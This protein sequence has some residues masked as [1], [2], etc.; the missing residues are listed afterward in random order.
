MVDSKKIESKWQKAW[1]EAKIFEL[2]PSD[3]PGVL[4]TAAFPYVNTPQHIGHLRTYGIA[5]AYARYLRMRGKNALF[6]MGFH[7]TGTPIIGIAKRIANKDR[8]LIE[9]LRTFHIPESDMAKMTEPSFIADYFTNE[10]EVGMKRSGLSVDWRRKFVSTEPLYSKMVE[11]QFERLKELG[12]LVQGRHPVGWCPNEN[13]AV[14]QHDTK[15]DVQPE[16]EQLTMVLFKDTASDSYFGCSTYRPET[17]YGVTNIFVN[18]S[19]DYVVAKIGDRRLYLAKQSAELMKYQFELT[20][21]GSITA[22]ELLSK[23]AKSPIDGSEIPVLPGYFVKPDVGTGVVMSVPSHAPFDYVALKRLENSGY[24]LPKMEFRKLI[25]IEKA[26]GKGVGLSVDES[27]R[28]G[29]VAHPEVPALAYLE[30]FGTNAESTDDAIEFATK[31]AYREESRWGVMLVGKYK[32]KGEPEARDLIKA[33]LISSGDAIALYVLANPAPVICRCGTRAVVRI[34]DNQ[35]FINY[36]DKG[37]K[38]KAKAHL[39]SMK[40]YPE[41]LRKTYENAMDWIEMRAAERA[42]GLGTRFPFNRDHIIEPLSDSTIYMSLYSFIHILR[43]NGVQPDSLKREFFDYVYIGKGTPDTVEKATGISSMVV[44]RCRDSLLYWYGE[45]S[46]HSGPDLV[47]NH[48]IMYIFNHVALLEPDVWPKQIVTNGF[49]NYEGQKMSKSLG[50]IIPLMDGL[51]RFGADPM[52]MLEISGVDLDTETEFSNDAINGI[53]SR[54]DFLYKTVASLDSMGGNALKSVD[55]WLYSKLN[56]KIEMV[57]Q[58]MEA[59]SLKTAYKEAFYNTVSELKQYSEM[60]GTNQI[61]VRDFMEAV[62]LMVAPV[63][64]HMAE[65]FWEMLGKQRFIAKEQWPAFDRDMVNPAIEFM[66]DMASGLVSDT[67]NIVELSSKIDANR[68]RKPKLV[69]V[70]VAND[71]KHKAYRALADKRKISDVMQMKFDGVD[72]QSLSKFLA[73][74]AKR[75]NSIVQIPDIGTE[76]AVNMLGE[77]RGY[78]EKRVGFPVAIEI[79]S[80]SKSARAGRAMPDKPSIDIEWG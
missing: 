44:K 36:G 77:M 8:S 23:S 25:E 47:T 43:S 80:A 22:K 75:I 61:A 48:L 20:I 11:W 79:E 66:V 14:G 50:N 73:P 65:E 15:G 58:A 64:P 46:N 27:A 3:K 9:E 40:I 34:V 57:S 13:N 78:I 2:E 71:W 53:I 72:Q 62:S 19:A 12:Y 41:K 76:S 67:A 39:K 6:A 63:M 33:D 1:A 26:G 54:I 69:K 51:D 68:G 37:W 18:E 10:I 32:G 24:P 7:A 45:N 31:A 38:E 17:I 55:Y 49:V 30:L 28:K 56:S 52:R 59:L 4:V 74:F 35:W 21:E 42:Q 60:G 16:I 70:I 29:S 5:D